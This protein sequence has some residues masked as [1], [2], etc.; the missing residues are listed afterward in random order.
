MELLLLWFA[1]TFVLV[2]GNTY[3]Y[4]PNYSLSL[5]QVVPQRYHRLSAITFVVIAFL[6]DISRNRPE[7]LGGLS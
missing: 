1:M 4:D 6:D 7:C 2:F 5:S 3:L